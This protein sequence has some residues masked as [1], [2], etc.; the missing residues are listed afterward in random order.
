MDTQATQRVRRFNRTVTQRIGALSEEYLARGRPLGAS[1][2]LWE[3]GEGGVDVRSLRAR[4][5]LDSGYLSRLLRRLEGEGLIAVEPDPDD[6]RA[7]VARLTGA[8]RAELDLLD[9]RSD[10]LAWS[11][12]EPLDRL[13]RERLVD[14]MDIVERLLTAGLVEVEVE[15][16][17]T[18]AA[19]FCLESYMAELDERFD[20]GWDTRRSISAEAHELREPAGLLLV[21]RLQEVPIGCGA[22]KLH[23]ADPVEI[24]RMWVAPAARG[25]GLGRRL[26][27]EL[28]RRARERGATV[29]RL[30][31]NGTLAEAISLYRSAGYVEVAPFNDEPYAHHWFEKALV[32][33]R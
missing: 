31:T 10:D 22:L 9:R 7:R 23:G 30:E 28:E 24:K 13:Q 29:A 2:V 15:D 25:L 5:G 33:A 21:A 11:L 27:H 4:L 16:P 26:L 6:G 1:R 18:A 32:P 19:R 14:A 12:L 8:G 17:E 3:I 20:A